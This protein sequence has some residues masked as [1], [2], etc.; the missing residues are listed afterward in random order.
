VD[1]V[2]RTNELGPPKEAYEAPRLEDLGDVDALTQAT[3]ASVI[4][5]TDN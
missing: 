4:D 5:T 1:D 2:A 3:G